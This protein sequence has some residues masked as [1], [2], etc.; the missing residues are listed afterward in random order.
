MQG[1]INFQSPIL[2][3]EI[4]I[5]PKIR[6]QQAEIYFLKKDILNLIQSLQYFVSPAYLQS[7]Q[8]INKPKTP[9]IPT[10]STKKKGKNTKNEEEEEDFIV[11][12]NYEENDDD[13]DDDDD[14]IDNDDDDSEMV[15]DSMDLD[16]TSAI[17]N[18]SDQVAIEDG[19][20]LLFKFAK[21]KPKLRR[22]TT[23]KMSREKRMRFNQRKDKIL[24]IFAS[25]VIDY[26][27]QLINDDEFS[28]SKKLLELLIP[29]EN[30]PAIT[31]SANNF[32]YKYCKTICA[33]YYHDYTEANEYLQI[34]I[35]NKPNFSFFWRLYAFIVTKMDFSV[36]SAQV[37]R[38]L[39]FVHKTVSSVVHSK[40]K[41]NLN[42]KPSSE[43]QLF[44]IDAEKKSLFAFTMF[45]CL[46]L[47]TGQYRRALKCFFLIYSKESVNCFICFFIGICC[48][49]N[50]IDTGT[51]NR[52]YMILLGFSF[53]FKYYNARSN[54]LEAN[55]NLGRAFQQLCLD[56]HAL[57][58][59]N[60][61]LSIPYTTG[62]NYKSMAAHNIAV[63]YRKNGADE[64]ARQILKR[65]STF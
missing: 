32:L 13:D 27:I 64:L 21:P 58:F 19:G 5:D 2:N 61:V 30:R 59:Y 55:Y 31:S 9:E 3:T 18:I 56:N 4:E 14:D 42:A 29:I 60:K 23:Q 1:G 10:K 65:Y 24:H 11:D 52:H 50:A 33:L 49:A 7:F 8:S 12:D 57:S 16:S 20:D 35:W 47:A 6:L 63:I 17:H 34:L 37:S 48:I 25:K 22:K 39:Q 15:D 45:G 43:N 28:D 51:Y 38:I 41:A 36:G 53:L 62:R 46:L 40:T 54:K 26:S 44:A